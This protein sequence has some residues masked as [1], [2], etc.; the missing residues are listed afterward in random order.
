M[1]NLGGDAT[2]LEV[3]GFEFVRGYRA[4]LP[5]K[6]GEGAAS[7][8]PR[9]SQHERF[10]C[11]ECGSHLWASNTRWPEL[12][13]PVAGAIDTELPPPP[14]RTH[15]M[16]G[17]KA[18]WVEPHVAEGDSVFDEYP[19]VSLAQW[20]RDHGRSVQ[21]PPASSESPTQPPKA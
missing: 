18:G 10:F 5:G 3:R 1:I 8:E 16:V 2:T 19:D 9:Q 15:M 20:H 6:D 17:S 11:V 13:H 21:A 12:V 14:Q 4:M 7:V